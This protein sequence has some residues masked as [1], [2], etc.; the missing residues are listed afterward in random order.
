MG[1]ESYNSWRRLKKLV[2]DLRSEW[3]AGTAELNDMEQIMAP[4]SLHTLKPART[5]TFYTIY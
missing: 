1:S 5:I 3:G 2:V 4:A